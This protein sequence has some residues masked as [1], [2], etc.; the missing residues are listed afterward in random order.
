MLSIILVLAVAAADTG[1]KS[2]TPLDD[3]AQAYVRLV[4]ALGVH[5][6]DYVDAYYGP[7]EWRTAA[8]TEKR[9]LPQ[10]RADAEGLLARLKEDSVRPR[11]EGVVTLSSSPSVTPI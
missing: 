4:L 3:V 11:V 2:T 6:P 10:I 9:P 8:G 1:T 7:P 5:D